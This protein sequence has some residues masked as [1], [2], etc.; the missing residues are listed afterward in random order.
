[1]RQRRITHDQILQLL[2]AAKNQTGGNGCFGIGRGLCA[3]GGKG[4]VGEASHHVRLTEAEY[5]L[6]ALVAANGGRTRAGDSNAMTQSVTSSFVTVLATDAPLWPEQLRRLAEAAIYGLHEN[7]LALS[8]DRQLVLAFSTGNVI[9]NAFSDAF[10]LFEQKRFSDDALAPL[11]AAA[12]VTS[13]AALLNGLRAA[14]A[15]TGRKGR[16]AKPVDVDQI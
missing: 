7:D 14:T 2:F 8:S 1:M 11:F 3:F 9:E 4:G 12:E 10:Q 15:V 5:R 13:R 6:G 16:T